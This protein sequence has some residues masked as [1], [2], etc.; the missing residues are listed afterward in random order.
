MHTVLSHGLQDA[1]F[2]WLSA[3][4]GYDVDREGHYAFG[5]QHTIDKKID[6]VI[7]FSPYD[8]DL[9]DRP[10]CMECKI[11]SVSKR[12]FTKRNLQVIF[13]Y[14]FIHVGVKR[15]ETVSPVGDTKI[16][17][18]NKKLGFTQEG[19]LRSRLPNGQDA[20]INSMMFDECKWIPSHGL[21]KSKISR[22]T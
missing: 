13:S 10:L 4:W 2:D 14:P 16:Q 19:I 3:Y 7:A 5:L 17:S 12:V 1:L 8:I 15:L 22:T 20:Y 6:A 11:V 9:N 18:F 21:L